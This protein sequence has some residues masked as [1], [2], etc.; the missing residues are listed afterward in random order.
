MQTL[1]YIYFTLVYGF[2]F[3]CAVCLYL[4]PTY[5][6]KFCRTIYYVL[7]LPLSFQWFPS[8]NITLHNAPH[9]L[10]LIGRKKDEKKEKWTIFFKKHIPIYRNAC[11]QLRENKN[12]FFLILN[13]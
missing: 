11:T 8:R 9:T 5:L 2:L 13:T 4:L 3:D 12:I 10:D 7:D 6:V 1:R